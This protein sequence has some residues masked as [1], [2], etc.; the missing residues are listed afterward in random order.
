MRTVKSCLCAFWSV[1]TSMTFDVFEFGRFFSRGKV[2]H[3]LSFLSRHFSY[4]WSSG[5][6]CSAKTSSVTGEW[7]LIFSLRV[8]PGQK[9]VS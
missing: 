3:E 5:V 7:G 6:S 2:H 1:T 8:S 4:L 9:Q